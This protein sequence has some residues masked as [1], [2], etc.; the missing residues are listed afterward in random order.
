MLFWRGEKQNLEAAFLLCSLFSLGKVSCWLCWFC[1]CLLLFLK[2]W[3]AFLLAVALY[4]IPTAVLAYSPITPCSPE[5][6][7]PL[8]RPKEKL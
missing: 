5:E 8:W 4:P 7:C 6:V 3:P 1:C 2:F